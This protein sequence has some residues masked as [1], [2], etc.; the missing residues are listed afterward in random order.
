LDHA[1]PKQRLD[2]L[3]DAIAATATVL[4]EHQAEKKALASELS[5]FDSMGRDGAIAELKTRLRWL[6]SVLAQVAA[7]GGRMRGT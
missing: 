2:F 1:S 4:G 6:R 5:E 3:E 7:S